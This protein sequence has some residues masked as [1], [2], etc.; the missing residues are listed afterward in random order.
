MAFFIHNPTNGKYQTNHRVDEDA[1]LREQCFILVCMIFIVV[2][3]SANPS[4]CF[5]W[6]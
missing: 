6:V 3:S 2:M 5:A 1:L 4:A